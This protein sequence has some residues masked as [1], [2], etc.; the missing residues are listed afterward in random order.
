M[1]KRIIGASV[2]L[3]AV[4]TLSSMPAMAQGTSSA[5]GKVVDREGNPVQG[6]RVTFRAKSAIDTAYTAKTNKKGRYFVEGMWTGKTNEFW[7]MEFEAEGMVPVSVNIVSRT[8]NRVLVDELDQKLKPGQKPPEI[9]V[10]PLGKATVDWIVVPE[11]ELEAEM[12]ATPDAA[13]A[14]AAAAAAAA[15][16]AEQ[17]DPWAEALSLASVGSLE[18]SL[19][20]FEKAV[21]AEPE[22]AERHE[23][24]AKVLFRLEHMDRAEVSARQA[25][26]LDPSR[27][28]SR[29]V[30]FSILEAR[31]SMDEAR[32][33]LEEARE[34]SPGNQRVLE[35]LAYIA[36]EMGDDEAA[37]E[38]YA[39]LTEVNPNHAEAWSALGSLYAEA[40][41]LEKSE[42]A[43]QKVV[44]IDPES[45][46]Q[47]YYNIGALII[48]RPNVS[49]SDRERACEAFRKA[50][51]L[52]PDY[53]RA[54]L[55]LTFALLG[56]GDR[57]G[58]R[59][60]L[61]AFVDAFPDAPEAPQMKGMLKSLS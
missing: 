12:L 6:A 53:A 9:I 7:I 50:I 23:T 46:H 61:Q 42:M 39:E 29:M 57:S 59:E 30:L 2:V 43:Y 26:A 11:G 27:V 51:D 48:K 34:A 37:I 41:D 16:K 22:D 1:S 55:E 4:V 52:K 35:R 10:R 19:E 17:R 49:R 14:E 60:V 33:V 13:A 31:G 32:A 47:T 18:D 21:K 8:V 40:G 28:D 25:A 44:E 54:S 56:I 58:A 24:F 36:G 3:A 45:A 15:K 20:F 38:A 5:V